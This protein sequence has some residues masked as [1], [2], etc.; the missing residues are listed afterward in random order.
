MLFTLLLL[1][2]WHW[3]PVGLNAR[4]GFPVSE[5]TL[6]TASERELQETVSRDSLSRSRNNQA[7]YDSLK[8]LTRKWWLTR[9]MFR[10]LV[11]QPEESEPG[12][13]DSLRL[14]SGFRD[15]LYVGDIHIAQRPVFG[16]PGN[17]PR[18]W[19]RWGNSLHIDTRKWVL[20]Q[21]LL[22]RPGQRLDIDL[23]R[24][25]E[26][27]LRQREYILDARFQ[28]TDVRGDTVDLALETRDIFSISAH[29]HRE[30]DSDLAIRVD[31]V[32]FLGLGNRLN[33]RISL[34]SDESPSFGWE[35]GYYIENVS[36]TFM[37]IGGLYRDTFREETRRLEL[38]REYYVPEV[39]FAGGLSFQ[40]SDHYA[41][42]E[43]RDRYSETAQRYWIGKAI[44]CTSSRTY[45]YIAISA[46]YEQYLYDIRPEP[47]TEENE[48]YHQKSRIMMGLSIFQ[49]DY[50][51]ERFLFSVGEVEDLPVG[52]R[53]ELKAGYYTG[54]VFNR[55]YLGVLLDRGG[56]SDGL[57][58]FRVR[59]ILGGYIREGRIEQGM[60]LLEP[61]WFSRLYKWGRLRFRSYVHLKYLAGIHRYSWE[62]IDI[63]GTDGVTGLKD[64][65]KTGDHALLI[66]TETAVFTPWE[67][68]GFRMSA[69]TFADAGILSARSNLMR[70]GDDAWS[71]GV[72]IRLWNPLLVFQTIQFKLYYISGN[73]TGDPE[74]LRSEFSRH[75]EFYL[76]GFE[77]GAPWVYPFE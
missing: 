56:Y 25:N 31:D 38:S 59:T 50:R 45:R 30:D 26:R 33:N 77:G 41:Y 35:T 73:L 28:V 53:V 32:N 22:V 17:E 4:S 75:G 40:R 57:G 3:I 64:D 2:V 49:P 48:R 10:Y 36:G 34:N 52:R 51:S 8:Q 19:E 47:L 11:R 46:G 5:D 14:P 55:P 44:N 66:R 23:L 37:D 39:D 67:W 21:D 74:H 6:R 65:H 61:G 27:I 58:Y 24:R 54:E 1:I 20:R 12:F 68:M 71:A 18:F 42:Q 63:S 76:D 60:F 15:P 9:S 13:S 70:Y 43:D 7:V 29:F 16:R 72:G 62:G 69:F